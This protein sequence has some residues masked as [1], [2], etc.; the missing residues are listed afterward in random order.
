[1]HDQDLLPGWA[2]RQLGEPAESRASAREAIMA[3]VRALPAPQRSASRLPGSMRGHG[4]SRW[5]RR[6]LLTPFGATAM[7]GV[8][9]LM[10]CVRAISSLG[11]FTSHDIAN[12]N[13]SI[14]F[15]TSAV[16]NGDTVVPSLRDSIGGTLRDTL[17]IVKF[18]LRGRDVRS[19]S[20]VGDFNA[21]RDG[22]TR[23][24]RGP[25]GT[26][27]ARVLI[28][29][30]VVRYDFV[31]NDEPLSGIRPAAATA[32]STRARLDTI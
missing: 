3:R 10:L 25:D 26:W 24:Q 1:M 5:T 14:A 32:E 6:G 17:R 12:G 8:L 29:R 7:A 22:V 30:D 18:A 16:V 21:W 20:V 11:G 9:G 31:V 28:P 4:A 23:L 19:A 2:R 13:A 27:T 15:H